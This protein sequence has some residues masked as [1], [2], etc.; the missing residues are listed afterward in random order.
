M[1]HASFWRVHRERNNKQRE[2]LQGIYHPT[3]QTE[4]HHA[5]DLIALSVVFIMLKWVLLF[6]ADSIHLYGHAADLSDK[7]CPNMQMMLLW[8]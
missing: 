6:S 8:D 7:F 1:K 4:N 5:S 2:A 3:L